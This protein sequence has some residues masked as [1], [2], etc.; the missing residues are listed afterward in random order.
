MNLHGDWHQINAVSQH[1]QERH[2]MSHKV[3]KVLVNTW[4]FIGKAKALL[5]WKYCLQAKR[6]NTLYIS[7]AKNSLLLQFKSL[8][9]N[10]YYSRPNCA[11]KERVMQFKLLYTLLSF[12]PLSWCYTYPLPQGPDVSG[13]I[14]LVVVVMAARLVV[15]S[16]HLESLAGKNIILMLI[17][18]SSLL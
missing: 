1:R 10:H 6:K 7:K 11:E 5:C 18:S 8:K 16:Q 9:Y 13:F 12:H 17:V 15:T 3:D 2:T 14:L 4:S